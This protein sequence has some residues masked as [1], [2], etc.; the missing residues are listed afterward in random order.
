[1]SKM[2]LPLTPFL[3]NQR[4]VA[5]WTHTLTGETPGHLRDMQQL[6]F[7]DA[8]M[9]IGQVWHDVDFPVAIWSAF[10][11]SGIGIFDKAV[12]GLV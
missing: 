2:M 3:R 12:V 10:S 8:V 9:Q 7:L 4:L 11:E 5:G 1:M 6:P